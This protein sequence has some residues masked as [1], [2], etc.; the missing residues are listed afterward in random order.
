MDSGG[1]RPKRD[2]ASSHNM[3]ALVTRLLTRKDPEFFCPAAV[4]ALT[5]EM[6]RL[7]RAGVWDEKPLAWAEARKL[8]PDAS[9]SRLFHFLGIKKTVRIHKR[10]ENCRAGLSHCGYCLGGCLFLRL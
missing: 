6:E 9:F 10:M 7:E 1:S 2:S 8:H 5:L 3:M 4:E